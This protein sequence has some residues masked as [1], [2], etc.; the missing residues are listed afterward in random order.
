MPWRTIEGEDLAD[1]KLPQLQVMLEGVLEKRRLLDLIRHFI[2][3]E[4]VGG[5]V[6]VKKMAG[7]HQY[8]AG[9]WRCRRRFTPA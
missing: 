7:Y 1:T 5:G 6:L 2:V 9:M 4:D 3:L 8:H